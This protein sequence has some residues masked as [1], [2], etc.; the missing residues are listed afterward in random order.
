MNSS[1]A[2]RSTPD[3]G[4]GVQ[5][6]RTDGF[7]VTT[8]ESH[9]SRLFQ[10]VAGREA[11]PSSPRALANRLN[12][13]AAS[14]DAELVQAMVF[15]GP[16]A[17]AREVE[18][19][20]WDCPAF[21]ILGDRA[22]AWSTTGMQALAVSGARS[23]EHV[24]H[25]GRLVGTIREDDCFRHG[26][27]ADL[28]SPEAGKKGRK[29]QAEEVLDLIRDLVEGHRFGLPGLV[30]TW[31]YNDRILDWYDVFNQVRNTFF[32]RHEIFGGLVPA[33]TGIGAGHPSGAALAAGAYAVVGRGG[34]VPARALPS[35]LQCPAVDYLSAFS[36]AAEVDSG[37]HSEVLVSGTASIE[38]GGAT[39]HVDDFMAQVDL[40]MRVMHAILAEQGMDWAD[41][42][43]GVAYIKDLANLPR[44]DSYAAEHCL[45]NLP[46]SIA[47]GDVCRDDLLFEVEVDAVK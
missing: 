17:A 20:P 13:A 6:L 24:E 43:R 25:H 45:E 47:Q 23:I 15:A 28:R 14:L 19:A 38:P 12:R 40:T 3:R 30:R 4:H 31:F 16:G 2:A 7:T 18:G 37:D 41:V 35:P 36:R 33:S 11:L 44:W 27:F 21:W 5:R 32:E 22:P 9:G 8:W 26:H 39:V 46:L 34:G 1:L 29:E 10:L 42:V